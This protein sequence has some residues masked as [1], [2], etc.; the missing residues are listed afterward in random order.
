[1]KSK[2]YLR[3][4]GTGI[5]ITAILMALVAGGNKTMTD[6][7]IKARAAQ[8]GMVTADHTLAGQEAQKMQDPVEEQGGSEKTP[9]ES[10]SL[11]Q[12]LE[13]D[14]QSSSDM[15]DA[16]ASETQPE[17]SQ[18]A[19]VQSSSEV[20]AS[21]ESQPEASEAETISAGE[22]FTLTIRS[23]YSSNTVA[24]I[25]ADAGLV[26]SATQYDAY[27]CASG[28]D[29]RICVGVFEIPAGSTDEEIAKII[30]KRM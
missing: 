10:K 29:K 22:S 18:E 8:L 5:V 13:T 3:G 16:D 21:S 19:D 1:M 6:E 24:K 12:T 17:E 27:L 25:L 4:L 20:Q 28:Y 2:Y 7:E 30:T 9:E 23:G 15:Q 26:E 14:A 11:E